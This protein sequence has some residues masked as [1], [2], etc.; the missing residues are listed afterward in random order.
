MH[1]ECIGV[2]RICSAWACQGCSSTG[3]S[4]RWDRGAIDWAAPS[5]GDHRHRGLHPDRDQGPEMGDPDRAGVDHDQQ[6][7]AQ[8]T[9]PCGE[10]RLRD[11]G[12]SA[13]NLGALIRW[14]ARRRLS[15]SGHRCCICRDRALG[16]GRCWTLDTSVELIEPTYE[17]V[18][19]FLRDAEP[20]GPG[21]LSGASHHHPPALA[22]A[23][24]AGTTPVWP[25]PPQDR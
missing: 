14:A 25:A 15:P 11:P 24:A 18:V 3:A 19:D 12:P 20:P 23:A 22:A 17:V 5:P 2:A 6:R 1:V 10:G 13:T 7:R 8:P 21:H 4:R 9:R 16:T